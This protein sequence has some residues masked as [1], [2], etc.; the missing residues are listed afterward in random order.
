MLRSI[1]V[2]YPESPKQKPSRQYMV[3]TEA[4]KQGQPERKV[5]RTTKEIMQ[6]PI[7]RDEVLGNAIREAISFRRK[8]AELSELANVFVAMDDFVLNTEIG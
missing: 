5:Y 4:A 3:V 6:D 8:Y 1:Q 7:A 2:I